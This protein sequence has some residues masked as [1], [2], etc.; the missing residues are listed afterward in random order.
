MKEWK[1]TFPL[2]RKARNTYNEQDGFF[3]EATE[4]ELNFDDEIC[5]CDRR[6]CFFAGLGHD[7]SIPGTAA[8]GARLQG[9]HAEMRHLL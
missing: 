7:G 4:K 6:R 2:D 5:I 1:S 3:I 9:C 8:E